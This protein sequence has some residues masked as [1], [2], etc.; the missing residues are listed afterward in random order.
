MSQS[1][2]YKE[3]NTNEILYCGYIHICIVTL[4]KQKKS[5]EIRKGDEWGVW[6]LFSKSDFKLI[7]VE[8][9]EKKTLWIML[10][11]LV[12]WG[13]HIWGVFQKVFRL[14]LYLLR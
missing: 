7:K 12:P 6:M 13:S 2:W 1:E 8:K 4:I 10:M 9:V 3:M 11:W 5:V 14:K